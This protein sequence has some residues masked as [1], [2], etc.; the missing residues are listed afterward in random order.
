MKLTKKLAVALH[1]RLWNWLAAETKRQQRKVGKWEYPL[2]K[3]LGIE[4]DCWC[5][6]YIASKS[7]YG[8]F[9]CLEC[10]LDWGEAIC[11]LGAFSEWENAETW[12][13][14]A[15]WARV[16]AELPEREMTE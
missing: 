8:E 1:R 10:P 12:Q 3:H 7:P 5:C 4:S 13:E 9:E 15:H 2:F 11:A 16:I 14:A 6:E